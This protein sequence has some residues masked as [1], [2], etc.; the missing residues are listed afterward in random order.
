MEFVAKLREY[1]IAQ[2]FEDVAR[3]CADYESGRG[4]EIDE[5][6]VGDQETDDGFVYLVK[7]GKFHKIGRSNSA[8]RRAYEMKLQLPEKAD[9]VH[10]IRTDDPAGIEA[11]WHKRFE[12]RR[13]NGEWFA[14][15]AADIQAFKRR[16]FM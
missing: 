8:G 12:A 16:K 4:V 2:G 5:D 10:E 15:S 7:S 14:L 9:L 11:Y 3:W 13:K 6:V 1:C